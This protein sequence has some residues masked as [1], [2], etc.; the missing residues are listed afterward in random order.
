MV[1]IEAAAAAAAVVDH[2]NLRLR[3]GWRQ[4]Q[5]LETDSKH[6]A[7]EIFGILQEHR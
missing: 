4:H 6:L 3:N 5:L 7:Q 2:P 1:L